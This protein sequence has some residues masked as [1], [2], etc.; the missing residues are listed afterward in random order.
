MGIA[1]SKFERK[2]GEMSTRK[3]ESGRVNDGG[4]EMETNIS[5]RE[6]CSWD[7]DGTWA[8]IHTKQVFDDVQFAKSPKD[9]TEATRFVC[10]SDTHGK[11]RGVA[12]PQGDVLIH[13][14]DFTNTGEEAQVLDFANWLVEEK[15]K[16]GFS[17][18]VVIAGNHDVTFQEQYYQEIGRERFHS[19]LKKVYD[20]KRIRAILTQDFREKITYI[21]DEL[22]TLPNGI[23]IW[24]SPWQPEFCGWAF[25][26]PRG[27][28]CRRVWK[29]IPEDVDVLV[30][31]GPPLG[32]GDLCTGG[33]R[34]GCVD[35]LEEIQTRIKPRVHV[36]GHVH[37]GF[38]VSY[39][40][41]TSYVNASTCTFSYKSVNPAIVFDLEL[42]GSTTAASMPLAAAQ[43]AVFIRSSLLNWT[44]DQVGVWIDEVISA[45]DAIDTG[46]A[47]AGHQVAPPEVLANLCGGLREAPAIFRGMSG[48]ELLS[49]DM[50]Q[51]LKLEQAQPYLGMCTENL[52]L[53]SRLVMSLARLVRHLEARLM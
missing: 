49:T 15:Q 17:H 16:G 8:Q 43:R 30:T 46:V 23:R 19:F 33:N 13:A 7:P 5:E 41:I 31:H 44:A 38:G 53:K 10:I 34:A 6:R 28:E 42:R 27:S 48:Q 11:H 26:L 47:T 4:G 18:V 1:S 3:E 50:E 45:L 22:L 2:R 24:G 9:R 21:E 20:P 52:Q 36:A 12:V 14:G 25:N 39:D 40:G 29:R 51:Y 35:L 32:R 37:E